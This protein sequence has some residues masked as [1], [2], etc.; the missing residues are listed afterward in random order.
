ML[1]NLSVKV[2]GSGHSWT[3]VGLAEGGIILNLDRMNKI[4]SIDM[5]KMTV[6]AE[7]GIRIRDL[8]KA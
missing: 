1:Q 7:A 3:P 6:T 5:D 4:L 2:V 8:S